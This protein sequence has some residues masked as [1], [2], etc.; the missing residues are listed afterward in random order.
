LKLRYRTRIGGELY[1]AGTEVFPVD[2]T[3]PKILEIFPEIYE[4][5][6]SVQVAVSLADRP[7]FTVLHVSQVE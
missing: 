6:E 7:G 3:D 2:P 5:P 1:E 4:N